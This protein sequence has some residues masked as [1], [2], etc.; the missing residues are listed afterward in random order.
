MPACDSIV[1]FYSGGRDADGRTLDE[2][3]AWNDEQ[4]ES[5]HDYVQWL[6][7]TRQ[8]SRFNPF[9][10]LVTDETARSFAADAALHDRL[11]AAL[12]RM[13]AFYGL[14]RRDV[15]IEIDP[16]R[17]SVRSRI[18]LHPGPHNYLRLTR[19]IVSLSAL[20][21]GEHAAA[22]RR[23]LLEDVTPVAGARITPRT[24]EFWRSAG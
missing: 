14:V 2:I 6:F 3:L 21:L 23:C 24:L 13:L 9:A 5:V 17:F 1:A 4:L 16:A 12:D 10:P 15:R 11:R 7:P 20:D 22:L 8:P 19:I 18:W